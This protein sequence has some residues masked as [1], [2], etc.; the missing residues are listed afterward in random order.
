MP[1]SPEMFP[2]KAQ[3]GPWAPPPCGVNSSETCWVCVWLFVRFFWDGCWLFYLGFCLGRNV[4]C[5]GALSDLT[6]VC[7]DVCCPPSLFGCWVYWSALFPLFLSF[8][9]LLGKPKPHLGFGVPLVSLHPGHAL[10]LPPVLQS[11]PL[12][13]G[14]APAPVFFFIVRWYGGG[15]GGGSRFGWGCFSGFGFRFGVGTFT[16]ALVMQLLEIRGSQTTIG[17]PTCY[18]NCVWGMSENPHPVAR[19]ESLSGLHSPHPVPAECC[20]RPPRKGVGE[21]AHCNRTVTHCLVTSVVPA[22]EKCCPF[23]FVLG[24]VSFAVFLQFFSS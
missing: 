16:H 7:Q 8:S 9:Q 11:R 13:P 17:R 24:S 12:H 4:V 19:Q 20:K 21:I 23:F 5:C 10:R 18:H 1:R 2:Q 14:H 3:G 6:L 15:G 22:R